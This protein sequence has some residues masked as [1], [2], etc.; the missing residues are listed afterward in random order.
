MRV[1]GRELLDL[2]R[3]DRELDPELFEDR[4]PLGRR[5]SED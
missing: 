4:A 1:A 5:R 2:G 3:L